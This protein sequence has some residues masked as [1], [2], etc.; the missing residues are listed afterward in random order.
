MPQKRKN[1]P[2]KTPHRSRRTS[3]YPSSSRYS[4]SKSGF[5]IANSPEKGLGQNRHSRPYGSTNF[6]QGYS[7]T[8]KIPDGNKSF[9]PEVVLTRRNLLITAGAIGGAVALGG[10]GSIALNAMDNSDAP[11]EYLSVPQDAVTELDSYSEVSASDYISL[12]GSYKLPFG[13][14]VWADNDSV[15]ACLVPGKTSNPLNTVSLLFLST[16][17]TVD[18]LSAAQGA[19][20]RFEIFDVR[21]SESGL[22]WTEC[23]ILENRWRVYTAPISGATIGAAT[24]V[25]EG[26]QN[27][28]TPSLAAIG[29]TAFW[30]VSPQTTGNSN[31]EDSV[32]KAARFA[33]STPSVVYSSHRAF[34]TRVTPA[35]DGVV[36]TPRVESTSVYYQL[37]KINEASLEAEDSLILPTSMKPYEAA[38]GT[39]GFSFSFES[40]YSYGDGIAN[41]GTYTPL[42]APSPYSYSGISWFHFSRTPSSAPS[43]CG[44]WFAVK[45]TRAICAVNFSSGIYYMIDVPSGTDNYGEYL[46]SSSINAYIV[47]LSQITDVDDKENNHALVRVYSPIA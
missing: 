34:A 22:I 33:E 7:S 2:G 32:L 13:T 1:V 15:A 23:N 24:L 36:I 4:G 20:E 27:W 6:S 29:K 5:S 14:L 44:N 19:A 25:D 21:C 30:Q 3:G 26:D 12:V 9:K 11:I 41:L 16:G 45:S 38:W 40:I 17:N 43:W 37:T 8:Q 35:S 10:V 46:A 18:V 31:K 47:G 42:S 39:T 28:T